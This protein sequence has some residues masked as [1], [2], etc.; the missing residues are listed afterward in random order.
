MKQ[1][2]TTGMRWLAC[3]TCLL[4]LSGLLVK[5]K[6][7]EEDTAKEGRWLIRSKRAAKEKE[8]V[9]RRKRD[10]EQDEEE[11][12]DLTD[13]RLFDEIT[14]S[15][16]SSEGEVVPKERVGSLKVCQSCLLHEMIAVL[17]AGGEDPRFE[18]WNVQESGRRGME[19]SED[20]NISYILN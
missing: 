9:V 8:E 20:E 2:A 1:V 12:E 13:D 14:N 3:F 4:F 19:E 6:D 18:G 16:T 5:A 17:R 11:V 10:V 15:E 7:W